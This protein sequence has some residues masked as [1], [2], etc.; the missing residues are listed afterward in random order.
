MTP[1][2]WLLLTIEQTTISDGFTVTVTS[3][4]PCHMFL[5][6][7]KTNPQ[8]HPV[9]KTR[10]GLSVMLDNRFCFVAYKDLEQNEAGDTLTHTFTWL[11][12]YTCLWRWF[13]FWATISGVTSPSTTAILKKHYT[14]PPFG[15][16]ECHSYFSN[17]HPEIVAV[18]GTI[19]DLTNGMTWPAKRLAPGTNAYSDFATPQVY[20]GSSTSAYRWRRLSRYAILVDTRTIPVGSQIVSGMLCVRT[21]SKAD[22]LNILPGLIVT[23]SNPASDT[24]LVPADFPR[25]GDI[26]LSNFLDW[27]Q[28]PSSATMTFT[29]NQAGLDAIVPGGITKLALRE[30]YYD[31]MGATPAYAYSD[32]SRVELRAAEYTGTASD[33]YLRVCFKPPG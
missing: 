25:F 15:P 16:E 27:T 18:D 29:L 23:S 10:R 26:A 6:W 12:W 4:V 5:R 17:A 1:A 9:T 21:D 22:P 28:I 2:R 19:A 20:I 13:Y 30:Y 8:I 31:F 24:D 32:T 14:A 11:D 7:S 3:D 33:P